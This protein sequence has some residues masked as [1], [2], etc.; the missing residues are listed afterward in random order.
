MGSKDN[1]ETKSTKHVQMVTIAIIRLSKASILKC[2]D[3]FLQF[4][5]FIL[6]SGTREQFRTPFLNRFESFKRLRS[7]TADHTDK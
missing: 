4:L 7:F 3:D 2:C 5:L 1:G 6:E